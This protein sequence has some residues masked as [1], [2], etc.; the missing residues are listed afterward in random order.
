VTE[1][2]YSELLKQFDS[3]GIPTYVIVDKEG[4]VK[5]KYIG[6]PGNEVMEEQLR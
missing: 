3:N 2:Q 6:Y 1:S 4:N 5:N